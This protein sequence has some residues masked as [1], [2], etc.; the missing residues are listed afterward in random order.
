MKI[1]AYSLAL[2]ILLAA[3][4]CGSK[5]DTVSPASGTDRAASTSVVGKWQLVHVQ[6][7]SMISG[8][9]ATPQAP[10]Y[11]EI[12]ELK[13]DGTFRRTRSDGYE[14]TGK[15]T[16]VRYGEADY[17]ILATFDNPELSYHELPGQPG[18]FASYTKGQVYLR[19]TE[20]G[21]LAESYV[22]TDGPSFIY[23]PAAEQD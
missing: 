17:G 8:Q 10:P 1:L 20:P 13:A 14:A 11:R 5:E 2:L 19:Q 12:F 4:G 3:S 22:A 9:P 18:K 15:Y 7:T 6:P 23:R 16:F 21:V